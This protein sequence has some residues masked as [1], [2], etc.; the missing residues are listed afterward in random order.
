MHVVWAGGLL[1]D[2]WLYVH[3]CVILELEYYTCTK[4]KTQFT[5]THLN[6]LLRNSYNVVYTEKN[7]A[8]ARTARRSASLPA[9]WACL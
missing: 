2:L 1:S 7:G 6:L 5:G 9:I 3:V 8:L 4:R